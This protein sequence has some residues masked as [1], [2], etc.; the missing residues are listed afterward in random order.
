MSHLLG[1]WLVSAAEAIEPIDTPWLLRGYEPTRE[2][3]YDDE[4]ALMY[5]LGV[6]Y[7]RSRAGQRAG[8]SRAG[9]STT[10]EERAG[11]TKDPHAKDREM[12]FLAVHRPIW[13]WLLENA[14]VQLAVDPEAPHI[15]WAWLVTTGDVVHAVGCKRSLIEAGLSVDVITDL[16]GDRLKKHQVCSL[17]LPQM[18]TRGGEA[19][20][21]DRPAQWSLDPTWLLTRM[22]GR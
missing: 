11:G 12:A 2:R 17:E 16:L 1:V 10:R 4:S 13:L 15:I 18:R 3:P 7:T 5:M 9:G 21:L 22:V 14:D 20:G 6:G 8:A 19:I